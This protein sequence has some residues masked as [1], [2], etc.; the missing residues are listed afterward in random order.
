MS[1]SHFIAAQDE[2][3]EHIVNELKKGQK[4]THWM[5]FVFPQ[6]LGLGRTAMAKKYAIKSIAEAKAYLDHPLLNQRLR[7]CTQIVLDIDIDNAKQIFGTP[8]YLKFRSS[9]TLFKQVTETNQIYKN[10]LSSFFDGEED[11][12]T[13]EILKN[14]Q[15]IQGSS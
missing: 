12:L 5:W 8:D 14:W 9:M 2:R 15:A 10:A 6:V 1:L 4:K 11:M 13:V 7:E 3:Y